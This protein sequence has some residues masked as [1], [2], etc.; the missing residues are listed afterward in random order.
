MANCPISHW[1]NIEKMLKKTNVQNN[2]IYDLQIGF[3]QNFSTPHAL[4]LDRLLMK[5]AL[6][7]EYL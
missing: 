6:D 3:Q 7:V 4:I 5:G 2:S 1:S